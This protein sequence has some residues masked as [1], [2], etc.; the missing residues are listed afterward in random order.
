M[1]VIIATDTWEPSIN[2]VVRSLRMTKESLEK[3]GHEVIVLH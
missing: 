2:G 3:K 1:K